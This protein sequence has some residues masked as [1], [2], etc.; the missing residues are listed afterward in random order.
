MIQRY[1]KLIVIFV[2]S[3][4][5]AVMLLPSFVQRSL[6][7]QSLE[8]FL[9]AGPPDGK[10]VTVG[11]KIVRESSHRIEDEVLFVLESHDR[12]RSEYAE[13]TTPEQLLK[14][15]KMKVRFI[16]KYPSVFTS[17][18]DV[19]IE[20]KFDAESHTFVATALMTVCPET[21]SPKYPNAD[22]FTPSKVE[23]ARKESLE[24]F[25][26]RTA[27]QGGFTGGRNPSLAPAVTEPLSSSSPSPSPAPTEAAP[28]APA[29]KAPAAKAP[30][31]RTGGKQPSS[32]SASGKAPGQKSNA[33]GT[34]ASDKGKKTSQPSR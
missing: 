29:P 6:G 23:A 3:F 20:G 13:S 28:K 34:R 18:R 30:A 9:A 27:A 12:A 5:V 2:G 4:A 8:K 31:A 25:K 26:R 22:F 14:E 21:Y 19:L 1:W 16:G 24:R 15:G 11:G 32:A 7:T 17:K 10:P 33:S